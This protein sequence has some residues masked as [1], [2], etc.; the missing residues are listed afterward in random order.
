M[1]KFY[2]LFCTL[3]LSLA[4]FAGPVSEEQALSKARA[5]L[6]QNAP[7]MAGKKLARAHS[8]MVLTPIVADAF[9]VFNVGEQDGFVL[10]SGDDR[11]PSILGYSDQGSFDFAAMPAQLKSWL[12]SYSEQIKWMQENASSVLVATPRKI[13]VRRPIN[14][15]IQTSWNQLRPF[16]NKLPKFINGEDCVAGCVP[17]AMSQIMRYYNYPTSLTTAIPGYT[18][19][20]T[21]ELEGKEK[22]IEVQ[23]VPAGTKFDY[24]NMLPIYMG[25]EEEVQNEAVATLF[26]ACVVATTTELRD[27]ANGGSS[28]ANVEIESALKK[29]FGY[30][31]GMSHIYRNDFSMDE[32]NDMIYNEITAGRPVILGGLSS[33]G[34]HAFII[35][36][37]SGDNY[38][39]VNWG[40]GGQANGYFLLS[41]CNPY[42]NV[43]GYSVEQDATIG[44]QP[45][46]S[47]PTI[48]IQRPMTGDI[49]SVQKDEDGKTKITSK[50]IS[51]L[52]GSHQFYMGIGYLSEADTFIVISETVVSDTLQRGWGYE[53]QALPIESLEDGTYQVVPIAKDSVLN[54]WECVYGDYVHNY[55]EVI[56]KGDDIQAK[57]VRPSVDLAVT[58]IEPLTE[59]KAEEYLTLAVG[60][61]NKGD[62]YY[63]TLYLFAGTDPSKVQQFGILGV[64]LRAQE[65]TTVNFNCT[66]SA[67]GS[68]TL[69]I[70][71]DSQAQNI[72]GTGKLEIKEKD[73]VGPESIEVLG[74]VY[75]DATETKEIKSPLEY[76]GTKYDIGDTYLS[77]PVLNGQLSGSI[78]V[79]NNSTAPFNGTFFM[80]FLQIEDFIGTI[81]FG[82][83]SSVLTNP[84]NPQEQLFLSFSGEI[85]PGETANVPFEFANEIPSNYYY[86]PIVVTNGSGQLTSVNPSNAFLIQPGAVTHKVDGTR[87]GVAITETM[88][89]DASTIAVDFGTETGVTNAT[90]QNPNIL[91]FFDAEATV[92]ESFTKNVVKG[93]QAENIVVEDGVPFITPYDFFAKSVQY[94]R[95]FTPRLT[96]K[97]TGWETIA[98]PFDVTRAMANGQ[99]ITWYSESD[100]DAPEKPRLAELAE[101]NEQR[102][103]FKPVGEIKATLPYLIGFPA[104]D[105]GE[106]IVSFYGKDVVISTEPV[107]PMSFT[108]ENFVMMAAM[109]QQ[110]ITDGFILNEAGDQFVKSNGQ[111]DAFRAY[112]TKATYSKANYSAALIQPTNLVGVKSIEVPETQTEGQLYT[113]SG[114][115]IQRPAKAGIYVRQGKKIVVK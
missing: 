94:N 51:N 98:L 90:S 38:F 53:K 100:G 88:E 10:V 43:D 11:T 24:A 14:P 17:T 56:K 78:V 34:G 32:W 9:Y 2:A 29:Y 62:E 1:R 86:I 8:T 87:H 103:I 3:L 97:G 109:E 72:I 25:N 60:V 99:E 74:F 48:N 57:I 68:Y 85:A 12:A 106:M 36:G 50:Y 84:D 27:E 81:F 33:H 105:N 104:K 66:P 49:V 101:E 5:F 73:A 37:Y 22:H 23:G 6:S 82:K 21:Y 55:V 15:L 71:T 114:Q 44:I 92:P 108:G 65:T 79:K 18:C 30:S 112:L 67:G 47:E 40:W 16:N 45:K 7:R 83:A 42:E 110:T 115:R 111:V 35:D 91:Y 39:H 93:D 54:V 19:A 77:Y 4:A 59:A 75:N 69:Y 107:H 61:E 70:A 63:G 102:L 80:A 64:S 96:E 28:T 113:I 89:F 52:S 95:T 41:A 26:N 46:T 76:E 13:S 20:T 58:S 31:E